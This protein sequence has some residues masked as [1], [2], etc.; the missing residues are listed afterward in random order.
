MVIL[1]HEVVGEGPD[2]GAH[3]RHQPRDPEEVVGVRKALRAEAGDECEEATEM[4]N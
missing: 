1:H 2:Q 4:G 3:V